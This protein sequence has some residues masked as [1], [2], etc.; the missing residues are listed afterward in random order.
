MMESLRFERDDKNIKGLFLK[1]S[2]SYSLSKK[3]KAF[4]RVVTVPI[5]VRSS[6]LTEDSLGCPLSGMYATYLLPNNHPDTEVRF[7]QLS[8]AV[9]LVFASAWSTSIQ[10]YLASVNRNPETEKMAVVLQDLVGRQYG[11][12]FY[13]HISGTAQSHNFYPFANT[14]PADGCATLA[15]GLGKY[16]VEAGKAYR[17]SPKHPTLEGISLQ[18]QVN[19]TQTRVLAIDLTN[20]EPD[21]YREGE[22][23]GLTEIDIYDAEKHGTLKHCASVYD[24][25]NE[26]IVPGLDKAGPRVIN[27]ANILKYNYI[28][29]AHTLDVILDIVRE[30][31]GSAVEIEYAIDLQPD[32]SQQASFYLLQIKPLRVDRNVADLPEG[33][34]NREDALVRSSLAM[35]NGF[36]EN[37]RDVVYVVP[38]LFDKTHTLEIAE[39]INQFNKQMISEN[40]QYVLIGPGRWGSRDRFIGIPVTWPQISNAKVIVETSLPDFPLDASLGSHFFHNVTSMR[41]GYFSVQHNSP[42]DLV[43]WAALD[44][45]PQTGSYTSLR[46]V[47]FAS[48]LSIYVDGQKQKAVIA[49]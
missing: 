42:Y 43:Q 28:P 7:R 40:R 21:M 34:M 19:N 22:Y 6:G 2:L 17:F 31:M 30:S 4:V 33:E 3:L 1:G 37:I 32:A 23:A 14:S 45:L 44:T 25:E 35:G 20:K 27:F 47:R 11:N 8:D 36:I 29:L 46:H 41:V 10:S 18:Q 15:V 5:A 24:A 9:K 38:Q 16:V 26:R 39:E 12:Y 49:R 13:P 48:P